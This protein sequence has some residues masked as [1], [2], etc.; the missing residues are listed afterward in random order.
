[1]SIVFIFI[2]TPFVV[3]DLQNTE[4]NKNFDSYFYSTL[5]YYGE[6]FILS[7]AETAKIN[8]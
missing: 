5:V 3:T 1:M 2:T 6:I 8:S 7:P 4:L